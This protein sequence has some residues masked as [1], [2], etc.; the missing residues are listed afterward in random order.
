MQILDCLDQKQLKLEDPSAILPYHGVN[1]SASLGLDIPRIG[2]SNLAG[3]A[4]DQP[5]DKQ[6]KLLIGKP[7]E[8]DE[9][10]V[11]EIEMGDAH[12]VSFHDY[13]A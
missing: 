10:R 3:K 6:T 9:L 13:S 2:S 12:D 11:S 5:E 7:G 8:G 4:S 1:L